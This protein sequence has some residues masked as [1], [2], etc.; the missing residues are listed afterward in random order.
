MPT[1][2]SKT[3]ATTPRRE[4]P[5]KDDESLAPVW[6]TAAL[7]ALIV[8]VALVG[9]LLGAAAAPSHPTQGRAIGAAISLVP[10]IVV[11]WGLVFYVARVGRP[12]NAL[13]SLL[14]RGWRR[15]GEAATDA[16][17]AA[18]A[19]VL[20]EGTAFVVRRLSGGGAES[21]VQA[22]PRAPLVQATWVA[23]ALSAGF[24]EEVVYRGYLRRQLA[25][26]TRRADAGILLQGVLFGVA[27]LDQGPGKATLA[28]SYGILLGALAWWRRSLLPGILCHVAV[29]V[30]A[31]PW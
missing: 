21:V 25:A 26:F 8:A 6:H 20:I 12:R 3:P 30:V 15:P 16:A 11:G 23:F 22:L 18:G 29:D 1:T 31:G 19:F 17:L 9:T 28:A 10:S 4:E 7:V 13:G 14:G 24:C 2:L 27:H 5:P